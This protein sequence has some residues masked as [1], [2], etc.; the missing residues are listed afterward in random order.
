MIVSLGDLMVDAYFQIPD[1]RNPRTDTQGRV[2]LAAGGSAANFA[3][4]IARH[5]RKSGLI[6]RVGC[7]FLGRALV[8]DLEHEGVCP[9]LAFDPDLDYGTGRVGVIVAA[10]GE[11]D[12]VCDRRANA[13]LSVE[14][15]PEHV[16]AGAEWLHVSGYVFLEEAPAEAA[17]HAIDIACEAG[18]PVSIDP[19]AYS[20]IHAQGRQAFLK[21][22]EGATVILPNLDEGRAMTGLEQPEDIASCLLDHFPVVA[23]KLGADGCLGMARQWAGMAG[24]TGA[25]GSIGAGAEAAAGAG[26]AGRADAANA[27]GHALEKGLVAAVRFAA[28]P[29]RVVDT[30][31]AGDAFDAGFVLEYSRGAGLAASLARGNEMGARVVSRMG[32]R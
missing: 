26:A 22:C 14:D 29:T 18:I 7:D 4:W 28:V 32:A 21:L 24:S 5:G 27:G 9:Y 30:T 3:V 20:F 8:A 23:L 15:V 11:R 2:E 13:R 6:G 1:R 12:M 25:A 17:R 19:A 10:D 16:V 31:G